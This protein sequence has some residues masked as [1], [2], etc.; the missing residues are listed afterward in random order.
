MF[1]SKNH[2]GNVSLLTRSFGADVSP[3]LRLVKVWEIHDLS[4]DKCF[5]H[6]HSRLLVCV[7]LLSTFSQ[8]QAFIPLPAGLTQGCRIQAS[9]VG[10]EPAGG[11]AACV[12][13]V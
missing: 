1:L 11:R 9:L 8:A 2:S 12:W 10:E 5:F 7:G 6:A 4:D 13:G 3:L